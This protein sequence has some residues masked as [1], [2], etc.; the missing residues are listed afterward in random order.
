M[1]RR[2]IVFLVLVGVLILVLGLVKISEASSPIL[3]MVGPKVL[4]PDPP[5][6]LI[7]DRVFVPLRFV[8]ENLDCNV[9]YIQDANLVKITKKATYDN[10]LT[11]EPVPVDENY[12]QQRVIVPVVSSMLAYAEV[13]K[14]GKVNVVEYLSYQHIF[15]KNAVLLWS[16]KPPYKYETMHF[17]LTL[18]NNS[19][20][21]HTNLGLYNEVTSGRTDVPLWS[22][23]SSVESLMEEQV[24]SLV[25]GVL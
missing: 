16:I 3:I 8:A 24:R 25:V 19:F 12:Y 17:K 15:I 2:K 21:F 9:E 10:V 6:I 18:T 20:L 23:K 11:G 7:N 5:P 13:Q 22:L 1:P 4:K 14:R